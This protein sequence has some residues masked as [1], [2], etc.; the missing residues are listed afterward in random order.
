MD[1]LRSCL[2]RG[3]W[4]ILA[5]RSFVSANVVDKKI[6]DSSAQLAIITSFVFVNLINVKL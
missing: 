2:Y 6:Q 5:K 4:V 1:L 3:S